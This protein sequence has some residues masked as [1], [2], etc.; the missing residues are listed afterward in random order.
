ML[1]TDPKNFISLESILSGD[2]S[3]EI[4]VIHAASRD[5]AVFREIIDIDKSEASGNWFTVYRPAP[6]T[7]GL[8]NGVNFAKLWAH[9][10]TATQKQTRQGPM[11]TYSI[12]KDGARGKLTSYS[13]GQ[14]ESGIDIS[15]YYGVQNALRSD[16]NPPFGFDAL[17]RAFKWASR[18]REGFSKN[19]GTTCCAFVTAC[20]QASSIDF[21]MDGDHRKISEGLTLLTHLR[22]DKVPRPARYGAFVEVG[23]EKKKVALATYQASNPGGFHKASGVNDYCR[24][25]TKEVL[26]KEMTIEELFPPALRVDAKFNY[27]KNFERMVKAPDSGFVKVL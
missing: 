26:G 22:G 11:T 16:L 18:Q 13:Y 14:S 7:V 15:R 10:R 21:H 2:A 19:R 3:Q 20:F 9:L 8:S 6:H 27:S 4:E 12:K 1:V 24:F 25:V 5:T 17:Y 23:R